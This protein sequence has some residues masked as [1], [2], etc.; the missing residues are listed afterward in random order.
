MA[1]PASVLQIV[2]GRRRAL[3]EHRWF[4]RTHLLL[5]LL[6]RW[7]LVAAI[8]F[9]SSHGADLRGACT[10]H[11]SF[12]RWQRRVLVLVLLVLLV[13]LLMMMQD[14]RCKTP[15]VQLLPH[16]HRRPATPD[17]QRTHNARVN[18]RTGRHR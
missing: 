18:Y 2:Y 1:F 8:R 13:L 7:L 3:R 12:V 5:L 9:R 15:E 11:C 16:D 17:T 14:S 6:L 4:V 10:I